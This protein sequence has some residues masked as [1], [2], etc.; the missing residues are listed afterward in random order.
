[1]SRQPSIVPLVFACA[2]FVTLGGGCGGTCKCADAPSSLATEPSASAT[3]SGENTLAPSPVLGP[4]SPSAPSVATPAPSATTAST[5]AEPTPQGNAVQPASPPGEGTDPKAAALAARASG[6]AIGG[7]RGTRPCCFHESVDAYQR[8][9]VSTVNEDGSVSV[10]AK[11]TK[12]NPDNG[13]EFTMHGGENNQ[14][15]AKGT[16]NAFKQCSGPFVAL[17]NMSVD[18]GLKT[19]DLRF[20]EH[21]MI[22]IR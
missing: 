12:L 5:S 18:H 13:F 10:S 16:L 4:T 6:P 17:V 19:Y 21:C 11:G 8:Q 2:S 22:S 3:P 1:M 7:P 9:C 20:K 14:W 15:V